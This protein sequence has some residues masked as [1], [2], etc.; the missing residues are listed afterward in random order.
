MM[1]SMKYYGFKLYEPYTLDE[2]GILQPHRPEIHL[3]TNSPEL[4]SILESGYE[5]DKDEPSRKRG[6]DEPEPERSVRQRIEPE[7]HPYT[8]AVMTF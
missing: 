4:D 6:R 8:G 1:K 7:Y 5:A 2:I 3:R